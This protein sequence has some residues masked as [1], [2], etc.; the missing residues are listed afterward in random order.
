MIVLNNNNNNN[1]MIDDRS[2]NGIII[3]GEQAALK[4]YPCYHSHI[5][6]VPLTRTA[7]CFKLLEQLSSPLE[8]AGSIF[9]MLS[10]NEIKTNGS[11]SLSRDQCPPPSE[12]RSSRWIMPTYEACVLTPS[13]VSS[14]KSSYVLH[15]LSLFLALERQSVRVNVVKKQHRTK[16]DLFRSFS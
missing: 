14:G 5:V 15:L 9:C 7:C 16:R 11:T 4:S 10:K 6:W 8:N 12:N 3:D 2:K 13:H 1:S